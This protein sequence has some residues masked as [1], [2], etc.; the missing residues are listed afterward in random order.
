[1]DINFPLLA[2]FRRGFL[3]KY[4]R[5]WMLIGWTGVSVA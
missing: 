5:F 1:M 4:L 2:M 3:E